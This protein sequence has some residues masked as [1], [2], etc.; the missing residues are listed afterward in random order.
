MFP[1]SSI[2]LA[3]FE[4]CRGIELLPCIRQHRRPP[5]TNCVPLSQ[6]GFDFSLLPPATKLGQ[7]YIFTG[8]CHSVHAGGGGWST[9]AGTP[10]GIRYTPQDQ[11]HPLEPG[12]PP[13]QDQ[14]HP[15]GPGTPPSGPG[16]SPEQCMLGDTGNKR[17]VRI[18]LE[19]ILVFQY[20]QI[21]E[22]LGNSLQ[23]SRN[24]SAVYFRNDSEPTN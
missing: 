17:A 22:N 8:I 4:L 14:V 12:T 19:C 1:S 13:P 9:W 23:Q 10:L 24:S 7:G 20:V 16:T 2:R 6:V 11:V 3:T 15:S 21:F 18:L 5:V